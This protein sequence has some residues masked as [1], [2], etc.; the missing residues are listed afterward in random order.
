MKSWNVETVDIDRPAVQEVVKDRVINNP[1]IFLGQ[2]YLLECALNVASAGERDVQK[3][4]PRAGRVAHED[5]M[6]DDDGQYIIW[7]DLE[8]M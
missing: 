8:N 7:L 6:M 5:T 2:G 4:F 1:D 3:M